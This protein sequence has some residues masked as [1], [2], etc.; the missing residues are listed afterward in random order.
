MLMIQTKNKQKKKESKQ[1]QIPTIIRHKKHNEIESKNSKNSL[2]K[3]PPKHRF[4]KLCI[5]F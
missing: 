3:K 4:L 5:F 1:W 2:K